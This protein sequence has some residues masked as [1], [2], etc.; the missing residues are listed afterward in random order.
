MTST[1]AMMSMR[2]CES[3]PAQT[4][5]EYQCNTLLFFRFSGIEDCY[6]CCGN[7]NSSLILFVVVNHRGIINNMIKCVDGREK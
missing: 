4:L 7:N 5:V 2:Y 6:H 3:V 1:D